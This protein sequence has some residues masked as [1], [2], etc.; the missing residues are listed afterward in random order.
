[1]RARGPCTHERR[2]FD[3]PSRAWHA[4]DRGDRD[5]HANEP[6]HPSSSARAT[7]STAKRLL[8]RRLC[9]SDIRRT[10]RS[11]KEISMVWPAG[12]SSEDR[13]PLAHVENRCSL[14]PVRIAATRIAPIGVGQMRPS[15]RGGNASRERESDPQRRNSHVLRVRRTTDSM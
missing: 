2:D 15:V 8:R 9:Q 14:R 11:L 12:K 4:I 1:L 3:D 7:T 10:I 6:R 5:V 13:I